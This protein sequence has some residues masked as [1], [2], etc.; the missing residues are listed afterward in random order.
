ML[1]GCNC[2]Q[3]WQRV[4]CV[5]MKGLVSAHFLCK[6]AY[7]IHSSSPGSPGLCHSAGEGFFSPAWLS[8]LWW[9]QSFTGIALSSAGRDLHPTLQPGTWTELGPGR[10]WWRDRYQLKQGVWHK[11]NF[12]L[13]IL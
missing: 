1:T 6:L 12:K 5:G 3:I 9:D 10:V 4:L 7:S 8:I 2:F 11:G 13:D